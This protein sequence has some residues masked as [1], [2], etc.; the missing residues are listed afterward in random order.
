MAFYE[1]TQIE[2]GLSTLLKVE[3]ELRHNFENSKLLLR[4]RERKICDLEVQLEATKRNLEEFMSEIQDSLKIKT[5][6][7]KSEDFSKLKVAIEASLAKFLTHLKEQGSNIDFSLFD[8][9]NVEN[10]N[11]KPPANSKSI[12]DLRSND[13]ESTRIF[14]RILVIFFNF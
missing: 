2:D 8:L 9:A 3:K 14:L 12:N 7:R 10:G 11:L 13:L 6:R 1:A 4:S 5:R